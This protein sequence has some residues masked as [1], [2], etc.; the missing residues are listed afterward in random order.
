MTVHN[1]SVTVFTADGTITPTAPLIEGSVASTLS[2]NTG[3][4][5]TGPGFSH[6][7]FT[8][9]RGCR[10]TFA[11]ALDLSTHKYASFTLTTDLFQAAERID[12]FANGGLRIIF[13]DGSG[14]YAEVFE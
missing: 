9:R 12:T 5:R 13:I 6:S 2:T 3:T 11:A 14:N 10:V 7:G 8:G 4:T 1:N